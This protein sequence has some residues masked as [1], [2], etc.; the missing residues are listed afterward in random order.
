MERCFLEARALAA[1]RVWLATTNNNIAAIAFYQSVGMD[2][3]ALHR[4]AVR[5]ARDLKPTIPSHDEAGIP[6]EH[7]LEFELL[8]RT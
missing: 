7:E 1:G 5:T 4:H 6:I 2:L 8:L 3:C